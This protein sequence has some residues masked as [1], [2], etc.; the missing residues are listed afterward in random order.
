MVL[1]HYRI[2][3][4]DGIHHFARD[5]A[6]KDIDDISISPIFPDN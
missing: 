4:V 2:V 5:I 6:I 1:T 3:K